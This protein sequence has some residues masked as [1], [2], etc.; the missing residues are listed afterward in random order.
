VQ[1]RRR[2]AAANIDHL[3]QLLVNEP[4][5]HA[6]MYGGFVTPPDD[7]GADLGVVFFHNEGYSTACGHGTIALVTWAIDSGRVKVEPGAREFDVTV[8]VPSG[9]LACI[10][11]LDGHGRVDTV[12]FRN[13]PSFVLA[14]DVEVATTRGPSLLDVAFGGAFYGSIDVRTIGLHVEPG[15][16]PELIALQRE[17]RPALERVLDVVHPEQPDLAGIYG[18]IFWEPVDGE[19]HAQRNVT[20][21]ADGE[22]DRS[23]CGSGSSARLAILQDRGEIGV[24]ETLRHRS[25]VDSV[26]DAR[27]IGAGPPVGPHASVITEVEG[28]AYRIGQHTFTLDDRDPLGTGFLLR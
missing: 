8:D 19:P 23:P 7:A 3:R 13:V 6:D 5:G 2:W 18:V 24:G 10:A 20:V 22:V 16:L 27:V 15:A 12:A 9:R 28:S 4:R 26:F 21:F 25:I 11:R 17:L 1:E 14:R